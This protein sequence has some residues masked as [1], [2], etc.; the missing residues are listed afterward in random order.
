MQPDVHVH[1]SVVMA[2]TKPNPLRP[3]PGVPVGS[4]GQVVSVIRGSPK[5]QA[6]QRQVEVAVRAVRVSEMVFFRIKDGKIV[7]AWEEWDEY[8]LRRQLG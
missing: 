5:T 4:R 6:F 2:T 7:E 8:G 1:I 3:R